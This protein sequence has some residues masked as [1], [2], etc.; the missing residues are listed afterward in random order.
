MT[1]TEGA[2]RAGS[3]SR[4][5]AFTFSKPPGTVCTSPK[6]MQS[7]HAFS[8]SQRP[9][10][11]ALLLPCVTA[12]LMTFHF[13]SRNSRNASP[14]MM[15]SSSGCGENMSATGAST[16]T[17]GRGQRGKP[18]SGQALPSFAKR[19]YSETKC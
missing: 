2:Q 13:A 7:Q 19:A 10:C 18:P 11:R 16:G 6:P 12:T 14:P 3:F 5:A 1:F 15:T 9:A 4:V 8:S 17:S